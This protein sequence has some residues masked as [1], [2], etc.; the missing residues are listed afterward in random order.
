MTH[1]T[2]NVCHIC[3]ERIRLVVGSLKNMLLSCVYILTDYEP[4]LVWVQ[5]VRFNVKDNGSLGLT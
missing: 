1:A 5:S 3:E 2:V 4:Y